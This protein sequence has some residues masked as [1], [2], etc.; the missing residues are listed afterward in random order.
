[1]KWLMLIFA[2][3]LCG[4]AINGVRTADISQKHNELVAQIQKLKTERDQLN[5]DWAYLLLEQ[6]AL[7]N[8]HMV[9]QALAN[10]LNLHIPQAKQLVYL[11]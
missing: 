1:M 3:L 10:G 8:D 4:V 9:E 6:K 11:K 5:S 2:G 7:V